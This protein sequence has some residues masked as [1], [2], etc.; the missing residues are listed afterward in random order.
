MITTLA[1]LL[2]T[3]FASI[4]AFAAQGGVFV[5][6]MLTYETLNS[7]VN[8]PSPLSDSTGHAKY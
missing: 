1:G 4:S 6:P 7:S 2:F 5:E 3:T 8:F